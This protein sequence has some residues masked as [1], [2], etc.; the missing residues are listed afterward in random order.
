MRAS[1]LSALLALSTASPSTPPSAPP[2]QPPSTPAPSTPPPTPPSTPPPYFPDPP[3]P[4]LPPLNPG[5]EVTRATTD[6][7]TRSL[8]TTLGCEDFIDGILLHEFLKDLYEATGVPLALIEAEAYDANTGALCATCYDDC[9]YNG[10]DL[11]SN[12][13]CDDGGPGSTTNVS[14]PCALGSDC[15]DC[16]W[17]LSTDVEGRR[18]SV[19]RTGTKIV[20]AIFVPQGVS[21]TGSLNNATTAFMD[22][23]DNATLAA[24]QFPSVAAFVPFTV[25][26]VTPVIYMTVSRTYAAVAPSPPPPAPLYPPPPPSPPPPFPPPAPPACKALCSYFLDDSKGASD[27]CVNPLQG[28]SCKPSIKGVTCAQAYGVDSF[29]CKVKGCKDSKGKWRKK[30]CSKKAKKCGKKKIAKK[31]AATCKAC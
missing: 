7:Q 31:C 10:T 18:L 27:A 22:T 28:M 4:P 15:T 21:T 3:S 9:T 30:K 14:S 12:G 24:T 20:V 19:N 1:C 29:E 5:G 16:G 25:T 2:S 8:F 17:Q 11:T 6:A 13:F 26:E 23:L